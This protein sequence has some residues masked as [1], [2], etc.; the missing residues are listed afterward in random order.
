MAKQMVK[1][2]EGNEIAN[3]AI[4]LPKES[5]SLPDG[6]ELH[7]TK[8]AP[9][10]EAGAFIRISIEALVYIDKQAVVIDGGLDG[11]T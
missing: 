8:W 10:L 6:R 11:T 7:L 1:P 5:I 4:M 3:R 9:V 2:N